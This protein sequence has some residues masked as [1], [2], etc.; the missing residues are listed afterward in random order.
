MAGIAAG[1]TVAGPAGPTKEQLIIRIQELQQEVHNA[2]TKL[3]ELNIF[4]GER[5]KLKAFFQ[6]LDIYFITRTRINNLAKILFVAS[7]FRETAASWF[8]PY[9]ASYSKDGGHKYPEVFDSYN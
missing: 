4:K 3:K 6:E 8:R 2:K 9:I 5:A 1:S 7:Y